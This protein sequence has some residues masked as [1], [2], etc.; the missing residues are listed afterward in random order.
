MEENIR[1]QNIYFLSM[2]LPVIKILIYYI[3]M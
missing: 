2:I 1:R 3:L